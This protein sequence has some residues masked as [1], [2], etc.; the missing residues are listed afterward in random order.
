VAGKSRADE[1]YREQQEQHDL[2]VE[3]GPRSSTMRV[4]LQAA[5]ESSVN[6]SICRGL[7]L[8]LLLPMSGRAADA[9]IE[10]EQS[11]DGVRVDVATGWIE[12]VAYARLE[13]RSP[14][15]AL[16]EAEFRNGPESRL[17]RS[18]LEPGEA[19]TLTFQPSRQVLRLRIDLRCRPDDRPEPDA[20]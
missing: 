2:P 7:L 9:P 19:R 4:H 5:P 3:P 10:L 16:C 20:S 17:R 18:R 1:E 6:R 13:N 15:A 8:C 12:G 14:A 11:V